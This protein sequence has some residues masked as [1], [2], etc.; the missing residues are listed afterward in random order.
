[1]GFPGL[2]T[3]DQQFLGRGTAQCYGCL[4]RF[5]VGQQ[6]ACVYG[7]AARTWQT[8]VCAGCAAAW[9]HGSPADTDR[10]EYERLRQEL[11]VAHATLGAA[12]RA[13]LD[14]TTPQQATAV[15]REAAECNRLSPPPKAGPGCNCKPGTCAI[16]QDAGASREGERIVQDEP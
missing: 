15:L 2:F 5:T 4:D 11:T 6:V 9:Q 12:L 13:F 8:F 7:S 14:V 1:M 10:R 3:A 16:E